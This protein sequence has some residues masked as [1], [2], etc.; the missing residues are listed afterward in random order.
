MSAHRQVLVCQYR[1]CLANGSADVL[2]ELLTYSLPHVT[3][4]G[5]ECQGQCNL[6][7]SVRVLPDE[8]WYCRVKPTDVRDIIQQHLQAG[9]PIRAL[10]NPRMHHD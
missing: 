1:N 6:G 5:G 8:I 4:T 9:Q 2:A 3:V 7:A 10:L